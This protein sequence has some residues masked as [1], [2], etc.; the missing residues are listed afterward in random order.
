MQMISKWLKE[1][2]KLTEKKTD[3]RWYRHIYAL[4]K[5]EKFIA[6]GT[7]HEIHRETGKSINQL[8]YMTYPSYEKRSVNSKNR[9]C[10]VR[11]DEE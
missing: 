1:D 5:G 3:I 9:L 2:V 7:I 8:K 4:Y 6:D 10:M 11:L